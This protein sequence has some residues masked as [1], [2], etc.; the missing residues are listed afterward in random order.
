MRSSLANFIVVSWLHTTYTIPHP[1]WVGCAHYT[2]AQSTDNASYVVWT[3]CIRK[4]LILR[5]LDKKSLNI[6][7]TP[8]T[9]TNTQQHASLHY[10]T[11]ML[12]VLVGLSVWQ[13][14]TAAV[15]ANNT[16]QGVSGMV[17]SWH[18]GPSMICVAN[19]SWWMTNNFLW[20]KLSHGTIE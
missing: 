19:E 10:L 3:I 5:M 6:Q 8:H 13:E 20:P 17:T 2:S 15:Q 12:Y 14:P 16:S 4:L 1:C 9:V 18:C 7:K 11:M